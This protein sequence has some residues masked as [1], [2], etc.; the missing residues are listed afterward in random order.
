LNELLS[1]SKSTHSLEEAD[2]A[3]E[4]LIK[5]LETGLEDAPML[6]RE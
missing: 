2:E 6:P 1:Q 4:L 5:R 3:V